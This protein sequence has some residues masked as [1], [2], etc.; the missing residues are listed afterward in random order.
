MRD[1]RSFILNKYVM[2]LQTGDYMKTL[3]I[4]AALAASMISTTTYAVDFSFS[5][6][7]DL[8]SGAP[9]NVAG[10]VTG[11]VLGLV[12]NS[13]GPAAKVYIDSISPISTAPID[14]TASVI[15]DANNFAV[16]NG[17]VRYFQF[18]T[19]GSDQ[20]VLNYYGPPVGF[21]SVTFNNGKSRIANEGGLAGVTF[22]PLTARPSVPEPSSWAILLA[23]AGILG[24]ALRRQS[25]QQMKLNY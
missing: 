18:I 25:T 24:A 2:S 3:S 5:F 1:P 10:T 6:S 16:T 11:R 23:G 22:T 13:I 17:V 7:A 21:N 15:I 9:G 14:A 4:T 12:D 20:Y 19:F 8:S